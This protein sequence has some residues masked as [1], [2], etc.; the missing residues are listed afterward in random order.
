MTAQ[1]Y[2]L[3]VDV[4]GLRKWQDE[5]APAELTVRKAVRHFARYY[6]RPRN[7][8]EVIGLVD[9]TGAVTSAKWF[10]LPEE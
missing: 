1:G 6:P 7:P 9:R 2:E 10:G 5:S 4:R 3:A 8:E